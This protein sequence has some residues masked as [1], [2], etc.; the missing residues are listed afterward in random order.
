MNQYL[1]KVIKESPQEILAMCATPAADHLY[2]IQKNGKKLNEELAE[3]FHHT[4]YQLLF[5]A[6]RA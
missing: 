6:N 2:K 4:T 1:S 3:A 5:A